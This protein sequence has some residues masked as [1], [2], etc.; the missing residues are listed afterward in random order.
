MRPD[1]LD[2]LAGQRPAR[3]HRHMHPILLRQRQKVAHPALAARTAVVHVAGNL[4]RARL[5]LD[6]VRRQDKQPVRPHPHLLLAH[7][8]VAHLDERAFHPFLVDVEHL[9]DADSKRKKELDGRPRHPAEN[10]QRRV[11][12]QRQHD[13]ADAGDSRQHDRRQQH[14]DY[15]RQIGAD[16]G[17]TRKADVPQRVP[18]YNSQRHA[19]QYQP[20]KQSLARPGHHFHHNYPTFTPR[21]RQPST[22]NRG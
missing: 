6:A 3:H 18:G 12:E 20:E 8:L 7:K 22:R 14:A 16:V 15:Q 2:H 11:A 4:V 5:V 9:A 10:R 17:Q 1:L 13:A 19:R 21:F